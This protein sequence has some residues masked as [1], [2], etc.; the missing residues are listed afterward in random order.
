MCGIVGFVNYKK[1]ISS[2]KNVLT[3]MSNTLYKRGPDEEGFYLKE[4]IAL[5]H[6]RLIVIDP[7]G[8]KQP[9]IEKYSF[10]E[11]VI[12]YNGQIYNTEELKQNLLDNNFEINTYSD[13]ELL[14]K[15]YIY[16]GK[17][18]VNHLN[19]IFS[20]AIWNSHTEELFLA[21]DHFGVKPLFYTFFDDTFIFASELKAIFAFPDFPKVLDKQG[22]S[23]LFGIGPA[24]TPGI[25][26]YKNVLEIKPAHFAVLNK[27]GFHVERYWK[28]NE[29]YKKSYVGKILNKHIF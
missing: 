7:K 11:Y 22:I 13:T 9:L 6:K 8:G 4:H 27:S 21:R 12:V 3:E 26:V 19:G 10:G 5:A 20:F 17:D 29:L 18:V 25:T 2:Y 24:H 14:L 23:E 1:D 28:Y 16:Y 15:S